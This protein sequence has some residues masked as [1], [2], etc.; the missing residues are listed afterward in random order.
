MSAGTASEK[1]FDA[2]M[3]RFDKAFRAA[4]ALVTYSDGFIGIDE[5][6]VPADL[7]RSY[8]RL[9]CYGYAT[10]LLQPEGATP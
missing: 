8:Q 6:K 10:G 1:V 5:T 9:V 3:A 4:D 7:I 2:D